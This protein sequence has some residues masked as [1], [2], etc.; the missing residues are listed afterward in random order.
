MLSDKAAHLVVAEGKV[1]RRALLAPAVSGKRY[2]SEI[3]FDLIE[4]RAK[5]D[6]FA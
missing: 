1:L 2:E 3:A 4:A 6:G 5:V